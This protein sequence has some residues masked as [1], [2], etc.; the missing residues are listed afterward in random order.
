MLLIT[1]TSLRIASEFRYP[2]IGENQYLPRQ[3][4]QGTH[5]PV[6]L[7]VRVTHM[8]IC[9]SVL[10]NQYQILHRA[11]LSHVGNGTVFLML[12]GRGVKAL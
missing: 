1:Q 9:F 7:E 11:N 8:I 4:T 12:T 2:I 6:I 5:G 3:C 10:F